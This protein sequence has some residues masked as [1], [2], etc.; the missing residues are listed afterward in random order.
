MKTKTPTAPTKSLG[1]STIGV[2]AGL[3]KPTKT[4][5]KT[6]PVIP[7]PDQTIAVMADLLADEIDQFKAL[8]ASVSTLKAELTSLGR[9]Q[10]YTANR[11]KAEPSSSVE[12]RGA[13]STILISFQNRYPGSASPEAIVKLIGGDDAARYFR[14]SFSLKI[15]GDKLPEDLAETII[16]EISAVLASHN[17]AEALSAKAVICPNGEYHTARHKFDP[18]TNLELDRLVSPVAVVRIKK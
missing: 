16:Q 8:E 12:A 7:D 1:I 4:T 17:C 10:F 9:Q 2:L 18:A 6:Y 5:A 11:G 13:T 14:Q 15:D 3:T